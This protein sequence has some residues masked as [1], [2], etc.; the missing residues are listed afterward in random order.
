MTVLVMTVRLNLLTH[1]S[2]RTGRVFIDADCGHTDGRGSAMGSAGMD[3][4]MC[5]RS[6][7]DR[8]AAG[9]DDMLRPSSM[10]RRCGVRLGVRVRQGCSCV[11]YLLGNR[12]DGRGTEL[13]QAGEKGIDIVHTARTKVNYRPQ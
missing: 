9:L 11:V 2:T 10:R 13:L 4:M 3:R 8:F 1:V 5:Q 12:V 7:R 6:L